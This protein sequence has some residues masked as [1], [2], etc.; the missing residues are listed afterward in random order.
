MI[1][2]YLYIVNNKEYFIKILLKE[3]CKKNIPYLYISDSNEL[4]FDNYIVRFID[5]KIT[6]NKTEFDELLFKIFEIAKDNKMFL[7]DENI[8]EYE[9]YLVNLKEENKKNNLKLKN[10]QNNK[11]LKKNLNPIK[12]IYKR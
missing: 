5:K 6:N 1:L 11:I 2:K 10:N 7:D 8:N 3:L 9:N 4:H 12:K